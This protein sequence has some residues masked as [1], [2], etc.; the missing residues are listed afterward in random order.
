[1]FETVSVSEDVLTDAKCEGLGWCP[2]CE[3]FTTHDVRPADKARACEWCGEDGVSGA[4]HAL[5]N[6]FIEVLN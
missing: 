1:M 3:F 5:K 6:G 2:T 4:S